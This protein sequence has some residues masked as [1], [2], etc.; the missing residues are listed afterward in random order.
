[1]GALVGA[2]IPE[3]RAADYDRGLREGGIVLGTRA[4]DAA[5]ASELERDFTGYGAR[6]VRR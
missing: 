2:G 4:K 1:M 3:N 5:H 6:D